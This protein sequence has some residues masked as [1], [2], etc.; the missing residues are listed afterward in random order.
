[1]QFAR[2]PLDREPQPDR[3]R[4]RLPYDHASHLRRR[5][6]KM[7]DR[8]I[9]G[10]TAALWSLRSTEVRGGGVTPPLHTIPMQTG[11]QS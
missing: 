3:D 6:A 8:A 1:M 7:L 11:R 4:S 10:T 5:A 2:Q 9:A